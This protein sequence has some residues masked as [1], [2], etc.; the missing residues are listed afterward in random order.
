MAVAVLVEV[1]FEMCAWLLFVGTT[2]LGSEVTAAW[3]VDFE[4]FG[5][6]TAFVTAEVFAFVTARK[7]LCAGCCARDCGV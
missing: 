5:A 4:G 3:V 7:R 1:A 2:L 6:G